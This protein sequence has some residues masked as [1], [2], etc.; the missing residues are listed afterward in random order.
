MLTKL[1]TTWMLFKQSVSVVNHHRKLLLFPILTGVMTVG[2]FFFF[3]APVV[4]Q[5]TGYSYTSGDHW[6]AVAGSLYH[7]GIDGRTSQAGRRTRS[8]TAPYATSPEPQGRPL[9]AHYLFCLPVFRRLFQR[10]V[11]S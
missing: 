10:G 3:A 2:I 11:L 9:C 6:K 7:A 8:G 1:S 5:P 4:L